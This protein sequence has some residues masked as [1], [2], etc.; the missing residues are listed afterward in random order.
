MKRAMVPDRWERIIELIEQHDGASVEQISSNLGLSPA[1]VRRDLAHIHERGF[2]TRTRGGAKPNLRIRVG[3]TIAESRKLNPR[4]KELIGK[5]A[6][7]LVEAGDTV[8]M[9][10]GFTT[11]Q[12]ALHIGVVG[13]TVVTNSLDVCQAILGREGV[14][15]VLVGGEV[16][17]STGSANGP[18]TEQQLLQMN[19]DKAIIGAD[20]LSPEEGLSSP[21]PLTAQSKSAMVKSSHELIVVADHSKLGRFALYKVAPVERISTVVTDHK[22]DPAVIGK[23]RDAGVRVIVA[24]G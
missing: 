19:A 1:T 24:E 16:S 6:A 15:C 3:F 22:A 7:R 9:D 23:L 10:G 2:I 13:I 5:A 4:E 17:P 18:I 21:H 20:V 14:T 12:V 11:Y 8:M